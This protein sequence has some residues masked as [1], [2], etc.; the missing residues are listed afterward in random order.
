MFLL[1]N[2]TRDP[3]LR[4]L[5]TG[6]SVVDMGLA[7]SES[8]VGKDGQASEA[9]TFVD[10]VAWGKQ[11]EACGRHLQKG[12]PVFVEGRL[13]FDEWTDKEGQKRN[14]IKVRAERVQFLGRPSG[15]PAEDPDAMAGE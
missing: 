10:I 14:K 15:P 4:K 13:Q 3:V 7:V 6:T 5:Q 1:G 9:V 2:L 11:A 12:A 8:R